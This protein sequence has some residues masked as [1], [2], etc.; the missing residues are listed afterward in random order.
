MPLA[1]QLLQLAVLQVRCVAQRLLVQVEVQLPR[2]A[3]AVSL[4]A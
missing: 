3:K 1:V 4:S 2:P